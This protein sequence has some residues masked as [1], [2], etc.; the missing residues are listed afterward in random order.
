MGI[1]LYANV[2]PN[3][4]FLVFLATISGVLCTFG[5]QKVLRNV[6]LGFPQSFTLGEGI[7]VGQAVTLFLH[8][9]ILS[10]IHPPNPVN[11]LQ[12]ATTIIQVE[13]AMFPAQT[14]FFPFQF[15]L[16]GIGALGIIESRFKDHTNFYIRAILC[17]F[18]FILLPLHVILKCSPILWILQQ[19]FNDLQTVRP[20]IAIKQSNN[21]YFSDQIDS[22]LVHVFSSCSDCHQQA[23]SKREKSLNGD[24]KDIPSSRVRCLFAGTF[25]QLFPLV[26][27]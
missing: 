7:L 17:I 4:S 12:V 21:N 16:L 18:L 14:D 11:N 20:K 19:L 1:L 5:Y 6:F 27:S 8:G 10:F 3:G 2:C 23:N 25:V 9:F 24:Q 15:G 26:F 13:N 22:L